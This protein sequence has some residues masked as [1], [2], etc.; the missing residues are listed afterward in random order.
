MHP[1]EM[2]LSRYAASV[3]A[4][5]ALA[6][7]SSAASSSPPPAATQTPTPTTTAVVPTVALA[8]D[9][10]LDLQYLRPSGWHAQRV[11]SSSHAG[12][13]TYVAPGRLGKVYVEESDCAACV[14]AGLVMHGHRN[15][16]PD[17]YNALT[18]YFPTSRHRDDAYHVSFTT[19][20]TKPYV[21]RGRLVV[22]RSGGQLTGYYIVIA[23]LPTDQAAL[24]SQ[25]L[26]SVRFR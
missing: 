21:G 20:A 3:L 16:V 26:S 9:T 7:C 24:A 22:T 19:A 13:V 10:L 8:R 11:Q 17:P 5:T 23:T 4:A 6:G 1:T 2:Q 18:T 14:D 12:T 25:I 15:G